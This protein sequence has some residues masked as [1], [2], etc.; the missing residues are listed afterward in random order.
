MEQG[1]LRTL[2]VYV[3]SVIAGAIA[4]S[5]FQPA[6]TLVGASAGG[7]GMLTSHLAHTILVNKNR[8]CF[9]NHCKFQQ[10]KNRTSAFYRIATIACRRSRFSAP[11]T[12]SRP[13]LT[14][15]LLAISGY[16]G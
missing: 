7:F 13:F 1:H 5:R 4:S 12:G 6:Q 9:L 11:V 14:N 10:F 2:L 8:F 3:S 15:C 16:H